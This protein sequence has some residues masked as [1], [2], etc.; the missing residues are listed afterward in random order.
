MPNAACFALQRRFGTP[1]P[2]VRPMMWNSTHSPAA[3]FCE[4]ELTRTVAGRAAE[5]S[6][7]EFAQEKAQGLPLPAHGFDACVSRP[8][9]VDKYQ[10]VR[11]GPLPL[12][13][14]T[15]VSPQL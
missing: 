9:V 6:A 1:V 11:R 12:Q 7:R 13:C 14:A 8:A 10:T 3:A 5:L 2:G 15:G 4:A